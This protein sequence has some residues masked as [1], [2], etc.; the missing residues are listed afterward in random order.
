MN[1][2]QTIGRL[3][4]RYG[5]S[6]EAVMDAREVYRL[7]HADSLDRPLAGADEGGSLSVLDSLGEE[8]AGIDRACDSATLDAMLTGLDNRD[9]LLVTLY[10]RRGQTQAQLFRVG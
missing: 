4:E 6:V 8:D 7:M 9:Q 1:L 5:V 3:S 10:Y 2:Q